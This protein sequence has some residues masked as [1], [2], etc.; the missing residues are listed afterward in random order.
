MRWTDWILIVCALA[1]VVVGPAMALQEFAQADQEKGS[2][3]LLG[4]ITS[5]DTTHRAVWRLPLTIL[6]IVTGLVGAVTAIRAL[7]DPSVRGVSRRVMGLLLGGLA[8][9]DISYWIDG[10]VF[11]EAP[12][13][14]RGT[15][16]VWAY[17]IAGIL[18]AGSTRRLAQLQD[19]FGLG[20][21]AEFKL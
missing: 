15:T 18:I 8:L 6:V 14:A 17:P 12:Y 20:R 13:L 2:R 7:I 3:E 1:L 9:F 16:I 4:E 19:Y 10:A 5:V 11:A 21:S